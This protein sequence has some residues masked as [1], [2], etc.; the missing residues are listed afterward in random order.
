MSAID[1][2]FSVV[3]KAWV[4]PSTGSIRTTGDRG[5]KAPVPTPFHSS[6]PPTGAPG[7]CSA[8]TRFIAA[9][10]SA[11]TT[12]AGSPEWA[13]EARKK[14]PPA[15]VSSTPTPI[16]SRWACAA[17]H[18]ATTIARAISRKRSN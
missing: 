11:S 3:V 10:A 17:S 5:G 2:Q 4:V 8:A 1:A 15:S 12:C 16:E 14:C 13:P 6:S 9:R 18:P 7:S